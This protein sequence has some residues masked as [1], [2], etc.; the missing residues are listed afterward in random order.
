MFLKTKIDKHIEYKQVEQNTKTQEEI[1]KNVIIFGVGNEHKNLN[2]LVENVINTF[3]NKLDV[4]NEIVK[5]ERLFQQDEN[6]PE[7]KKIKKIPIV[8]EFKNNEVKLQIF[9][10]QKQ[11]KECYSEECGITDDNTR[12]TIRDQLSSSNYTIIKEA[13]KLRNY[14]IIKYVWFQDSKVLV[15][16]SDNSKIFGIKIL[17]D[18]EKFKNSSN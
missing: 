6:V 2:K 10:A 18:L 4:S 11:K 17:S 12:I 3:D 15:R 16:K 9:K 1:N 7:S 5:V 8:V 14:G 13:S